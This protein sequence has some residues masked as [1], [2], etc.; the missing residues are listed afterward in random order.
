[1]KIAYKIDKKWCDIQLATRTIN[2]IFIKHLKTYLLQWRYQ[3]ILVKNV[4][5]DILTQIC[6]ES[7]LDNLSPKEW[8]NDLQLVS[9]AAS[10][11]KSKR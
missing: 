11:A 9:D 4:T 1:M 3:P 6:H 2:F 7:V 10:F 8:W 5:T